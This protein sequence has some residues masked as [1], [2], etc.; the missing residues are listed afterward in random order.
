MEKKPYENP[1]IR[2][3]TFCSEHVVLNDSDQ[4]PSSDEFEGGDY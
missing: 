2:I 1:R 3:I 4:L